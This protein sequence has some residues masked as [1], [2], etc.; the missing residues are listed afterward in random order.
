MKNTI[1]TIYT[2]VALEMYNYVYYLKIMNLFETFY[3][4]KS[5]FYIGIISLKAWR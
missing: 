1:Y 4:W 3:Y 5:Y 2:N